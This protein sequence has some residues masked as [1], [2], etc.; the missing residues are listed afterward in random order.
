MLY[1]KVIVQVLCGLFDTKTDETSK[2]C[3]VSRI[4][5]VSNV[6]SRKHNVEVPLDSTFQMRI[7]LYEFSCAVLLYSLRQI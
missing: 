1:T 2:I 5:M 7:A 4:Y 3:G 6:A